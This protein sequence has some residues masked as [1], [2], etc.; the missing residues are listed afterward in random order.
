[1]SKQAAMAA[2]GPQAGMERKRRIDEAEATDGGASSVAVNAPCAK[3][4]GEESD[5]IALGHVPAPSTEERRPFVAGQ[6]ITI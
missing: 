2:A 3:A 1:M 5:T 4:G 6:Y